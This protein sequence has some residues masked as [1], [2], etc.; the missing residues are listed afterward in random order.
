MTMTNEEL[1]AIED[2][3]IRHA[4]DIPLIRSYIPVLIAEVKRLQTEL[5]AVRIACAAYKALATIC[6]ECGG[7]CEV[8]SGYISS[9]GDALST[10]CPT[11]DGTGKAYADTVDTPPTSGFFTSGRWNF[12]EQPKRIG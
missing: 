7:S 3:S 2:R 9:C 6:P 11:C 12:T 4:G 8:D 5:A 1:I 10:T